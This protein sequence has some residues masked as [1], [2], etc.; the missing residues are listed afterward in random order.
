MKIN[1]HQAKTHFSRL[2]EKALSGEEII[3]ARNGQPLIKLV[4]LK[5]LKAQRVPGLSSGRGR[6]SEDFDSP[7]PPELLAE[8]E[9]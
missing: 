6:V 9:Q 1:M 3:I 2:V 4:P 8:F 7:L 5:N